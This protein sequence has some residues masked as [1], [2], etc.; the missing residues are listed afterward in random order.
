MICPSCKTSVDQSPIGH[1]GGYCNHCG[2][3]Y[4]TVRLI[5]LTPHAITLKHDG[6][7]PVLIPYKAGLFSYS[8]AVF[9]LQN[10]W[11]ADPFRIF[12]A[13]GKVVCFLYSF[14]SHRASR[15]SLASVTATALFVCG[16][17]RI[18]CIVKEH[19]CISPG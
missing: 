16:R 19:G 13:F 2:D 4:W 17:V 9:P 12:Q 5:N 7:I 18:G 11:V 1:F 3:M 10:Q 15:E 8:L 6:T 14:W